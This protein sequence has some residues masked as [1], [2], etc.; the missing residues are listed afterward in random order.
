[1]NLNLLSSLWLQRI[2]IEQKNIDLG[3]NVWLGLL[4]DESR[5]L[6]ELAISRG[7]GIVR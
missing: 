7:H 4:A 1:L 5:T 3:E 2:T 6:D